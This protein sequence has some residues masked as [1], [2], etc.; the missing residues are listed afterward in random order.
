MP[1]ADHGARDQSHVLPGRRRSNPS[2]CDLQIIIRR[3]AK[4]PGRYEK[5]GWRLAKGLL[6]LLLGKSWLLIWSRRTGNCLVA[7]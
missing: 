2:A 3:A 5:A 6:T 4:N 7:V 1:V